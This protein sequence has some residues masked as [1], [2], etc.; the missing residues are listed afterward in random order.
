MVRERG[1]G[2]VR[3]HRQPARGAARSQ[4]AASAARD[5][6]LQARLAIKSAAHGVSSGE[7]AQ[8]RIDLE[9]AR[10]GVDTAAL[11]LST[12]RLRLRDARDVAR[13]TT[14]IELAVQN[15]R[16]D[17]KLAAADVALKRATL[18]KAIDAHTEAQR[19]VAEAPPTARRP[20]AR[21]S[22]PRSSRR[23]TTLPWPS[24]T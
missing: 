13:R 14:G 9:A 3:R 22:S 20:S 4:R 16:R 23:P 19:T 17:N 1:L 18:N 11:G 12:A 24:S 8:A 7:L 6:H 10:D 5:L 21:P 2:A 15:A